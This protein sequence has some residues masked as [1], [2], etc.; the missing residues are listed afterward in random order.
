M[1]LAQINEE[2]TIL[3]ILLIE[4]DPDYRCLVLTCPPSFAKEIIRD[5][6]SLR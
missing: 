4:D 6:L 1:I 2:T 5:P 3:N